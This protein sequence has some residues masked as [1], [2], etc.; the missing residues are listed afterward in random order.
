MSATRDPSKWVKAA[1]SGNQ[2]A[3]VEMRQH[4]NAVEVRDTKDAGDGPTLRFTADEFAAWVDGAK[5][6]EFDH[7]M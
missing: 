7:L 5:R 2:G 4:S 3:C 1:A 6:G